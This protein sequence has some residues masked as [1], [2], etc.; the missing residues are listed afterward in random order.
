MVCIF[1]ILVKMKKK[2]WGKI[3]MLVNSI[4][5]MLYSILGN[6][7]YYPNLHQCHSGLPIQ[8]N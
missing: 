4:S 5:F 2:V 3:A 6:Q 1:Y 7:K 8:F